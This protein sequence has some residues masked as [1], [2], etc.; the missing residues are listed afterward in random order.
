M[1][2][3]R[4]C[5]GVLTL[6][7]LAVAA[8]AAQDAKQETFARVDAMRE[9]LVDISDKIWEYAEIELSEKRSSKL[10]ADMLEAAGFTVE[11]G[12][13]GL[14]T[15]F[16]ATWGSG[17]PCI[18]IL[19]EYDALP[20]ISQERGNPVKT[21]LVEGGAGHG[22]GHNIFGTACVGAAIAL[23]ETMVAHE[24]PGTLILYGC[25][26]EETVVGKVIMAREGLFEGLDAAITWHPGQRTKVTLMQS[27]ALNNF[28]ITFTGRTAHG[29]ADPWNG[30]SALDALEML[31]FGIN[32]M[33][34]HVKPTVRIHYV[35]KDGG[36]APNVVP[37]KATGWYYV[38]D[39]TREGVSHVFRRLLKIAEGAALATETQMQLKLITG[40]HEE[41]VNSVIAETHLK[42]LELVGPPQF[43][44]EE[45]EFAQE[46]Q[47]TLGSEETGLRTEIE[48]FEPGEGRGS[49]DV[50]EVSW[51][52]PLAEF[53]VAM[54]PLETPWHS[55]VVVSCGG[56]SLGHKAMMVAAKVLA[57]SGLDLFTDADLLRRA[58]AEFEKNTADHPYVSPLDESYEN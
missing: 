2:H 24:I 22:C 4:I 15:A 30:R 48:P 46:L 37:D 23:K 47:R 20:G 41:L 29:A 49:T 26:A 12:V 40:V 5:A 3:R 58:R 27:L 51:L 17:S 11:R 35:V 10:L 31:N 50:A 52:T 21:P 34:E 38:R 19:A 25:P 54:A 16:M 7:T 33:R 32:L 53:S 28:E 1:T 56:T 36:G 39:S 6:L 55:W 45:Q 44:E 42:N 57:G 13:A 9:K 18:G 43:S 8:A 14:E